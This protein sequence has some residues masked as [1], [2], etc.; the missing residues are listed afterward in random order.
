MSNITFDAE[1]KTKTAKEDIEWLRIWCENTNDTALPRVAL[2]G[3]SITEGYFRFVLK[4][5]EGKAR[6]DVL[7]TSYSIQSDAYQKMVKSFVDDSHY[8]VVHFNYGLHAYAVDDETYEEKCAEM[9]DYFA[10]QAKLVVATST[11]VLERDLQTEQTHWKDKLIARNARLVKVAQEKGILVNDLN[12]LSKELLGAYRME[13]GVHF[14]E[15]GYQAL[16][17]LVVESI[18]KVL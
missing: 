7:V 2:I 9:V 17:D 3:D 15:K 8:A 14:S 16:A 6:V 18:E 10:K 1:G 13:D 11:I 5:L 4:A 12:A